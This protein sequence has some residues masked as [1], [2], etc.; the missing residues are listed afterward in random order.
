MNATCAM[1]MT[2]LATTVEDLAS[3]ITLLRRA[4]VVEEHRCFHQ[5]QSQQ[6]R[7]SGNVLPLQQ[8]HNLA[9]DCLLQAA[10]TLLFLANACPQL[11]A[12]LSAHIAAHTGIARVVALELP[13]SI[14]LSA[15][16]LQRR[17]TPHTPLPSAAPGMC[18][19]AA[20]RGTANTAKKGRRRR[21]QQPP[22]DP[23]RKSERGSQDDRH[24]L[25]AS[26][27]PQSQLAGQLELAAD[28]IRRSG[29]ATNGG[30]MEPLLACEN[31]DSRL[32]DEYAAI[33]LPGQVEQAFAQLTEQQACLRLLMAAQVLVVL[34]C[35]LGS[36]AREEAGA[37]LGMCWCLVDLT[38]ALPAKAG[39]RG[40][41][42]PGAR[43]DLSCNGSSSGAPQLL[44]KLS[45][46]F[47]A[48]AA[49]APKADRARR[50]NVCLQLHAMLKKALGGLS[51]E[52]Q[53]LVPPPPL[54]LP[55]PEDTAA[56]AASNAMMRLLLEVRLV[57]A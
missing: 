15:S 20:F 26:P 27:A 50:H 48:A 37:A 3:A 30:H 34:S 5:R 40:S 38:P 42:G 32:A 19:T 47:A 28:A 13:I 1:Q 29:V 44:H 12:V 21:K 39:M 49:A 7:A 2:V 41:G 51:G 8:Y 10:A 43:Q 24:S 16:V 6:G 11:P 22:E 36:A 33:L 4:A 52:W 18:A 55:T 9:V 45:H 46:L 56:Q 25:P 17:W 23:G 14:A 57:A 53:V 54:L 31:S 35:C